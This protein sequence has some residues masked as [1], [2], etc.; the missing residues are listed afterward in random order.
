MTK[1]MTYGA[2]KQHKVHV[3]QVLKMFIIFALVTDAEAYFLERT[4]SS[5]RRPH[6]N[7]PSRL[8]AVNV[9]APGASYNPVAVDH[10]ALLLQAHEVEVK[11]VGG[12]S[13]LFQNEP[14]FALFAEKGK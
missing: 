2:I 13:M 11:K 14:N 12:T 9:P 7:R 5:K 1:A 8:A 10:K 6:R 4:Q 3:L